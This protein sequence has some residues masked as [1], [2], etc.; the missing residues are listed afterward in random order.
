MTSERTYRSRRLQWARALES[1]DFKQTNSTLK[2]GRG[3]GASHCCLGVGCE[4]M[5]LV[6]QNQGNSF[7]AFPS[8]YSER[9]FHSMPPVDLAIWLGL[10]KK[11]QQGSINI[12]AW[13][14]HDEAWCT[15]GE[16]CR[17]KGH[18][19]SLAD[20]NDRY[21]M[22]FHQIADAIRNAELKCL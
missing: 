10:R 5:G 19:I 6:P 20:M 8:E 22:D 4:V 7:V 21:D 13:M 9:T 12:F 1:G 2:R 15:E 11:G 18:W 16:E 17:K 14:Y 3:K